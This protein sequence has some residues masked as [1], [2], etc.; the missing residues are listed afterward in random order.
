MNPNGERV[1]NRL[2]INMNILRKALSY[3]LVGA[4]LAGT[5]VFAQ[6]PGENHNRPEQNRPGNDHRPGNNR[7][8]NNR[9]GNNRPGQGHSNY[10]PGHSGGHRP[11]PPQGFRS[12]Y[13]RHS[14]WRRGY[15]MPPS[16][17]GRAY[18]VNDWG[19]YGLYAPPAG[20]EWRYIDGQYILAA[21]ATGI[22]SS[23][24]LAAAAN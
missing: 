15:R 5:G 16:Y 3:S 24:I 7:P 21:V 8:N 2:E 6:R 23:I 18:V 9:P 19:S 1:S 11:G 12:P 14:R 13:V 17:W 4:L 20:Y 22:I 10:R